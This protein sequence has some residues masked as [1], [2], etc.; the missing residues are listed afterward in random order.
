MDTRY[1]IFI[2]LGVVV[3]W[4]ANRALPQKAFEYLVYVL[5]FVT[6]L[7]LLRN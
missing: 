5:L 2:P 3:G 7:Q 6:S 4:L 1:L